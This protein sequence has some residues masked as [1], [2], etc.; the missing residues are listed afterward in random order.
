MNLLIV[1]VFRSFNWLSFI[2]F[3]ETATFAGNAV[4]Y[5]SKQRH[6]KGK[7]TNV[8]ESKV[9]TIMYVLRLS[10]IYVKFFQRFHQQYYQMKQNLFRNLS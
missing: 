8:I 9:P 2:E 6:Y 5:I 1:V 3:Y 10:V 7:K 4:T